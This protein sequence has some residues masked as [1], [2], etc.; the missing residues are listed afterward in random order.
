MTDHF[1]HHLTDQETIQ[2]QLLAHCFL[3]DYAKVY[4]YLGSSLKAELSQEAFIPAAQQQ[5]E[6]CEKTLLLTYSL[7]LHDS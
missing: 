2:N 1:A 3:Q 5:K 4:T 6:V 7:L